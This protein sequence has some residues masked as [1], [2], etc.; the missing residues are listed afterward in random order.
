MGYTHYF[1]KETWT[2]ADEKGFKDALPTVRDIVKRHRKLLQ[3]E[4]NDAGD[5]VVDENE[6]RFNGIEENGHETFL[7]SNRQ[8]RFEFCKTA[9]KPYDVAACE[10]L[11]VM[12]KYCPNLQVSSDGF[13][14][15][16]KDPKPDQG[17]QVAVENLRENYG[18]KYRVVVTKEREPYCDLDLVLETQD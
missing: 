13:S 7:L 9:E 4:H 6:I 3:L 2:P 14:A 12:K 11:L 15:C 18:I 5:P 10:V 8:E 17:W 1:R 16:L